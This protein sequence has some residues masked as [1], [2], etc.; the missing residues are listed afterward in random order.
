MR[1][2]EK[3]ENVLIK[4]VAH[5]HISNFQISTSKFT[6]SKHYELKSSLSERDQQ[7]IWHPYTQHQLSGSPIPIIR[8]EERF[9]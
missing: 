5:L 7:V 3:C 4:S 8:G 6:I 1:K 2:Y 9:I